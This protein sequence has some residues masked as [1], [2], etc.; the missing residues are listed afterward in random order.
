MVDMGK[1]KVECPEC[2]AIDDVDESDF[3]NKVICNHCG[4]TIIPEK[5]MVKCM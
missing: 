3:F 4:G 1:V 5:D 2:G